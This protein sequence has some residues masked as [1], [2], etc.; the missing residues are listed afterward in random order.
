[1]NT[2]PKDLYCMCVGV[3]ISTGIYC[4]SGGLGF[5]KCQG[6]RSIETAGYPTVFSSASS[7]FLNSTTRVNC[8]CPCAN[9]F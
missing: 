7:A 3:F 2:D 8:F 6:S 4:L 1:M 9:I 5:K